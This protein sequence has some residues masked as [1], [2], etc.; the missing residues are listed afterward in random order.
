M[1][2]LRR[3]GWLL[4]EM[5]E[6]IT[7]DYYKNNFLGKLVPEEDFEHIEKKAVVYVNYALVGNLG[8][9]D[10]EKDA[11]CAACELIYKEKDRSGIKSENTDGYSVTFDT[12]SDFTLKI[13]DEIKIYLAN[14]GKLYRGI[15]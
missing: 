1:P 5:I 6:I 11:V 4:K 10:A 2:P 9:S 8:D 3:C 15:Y 7:Y 13:L 12:G 14:S